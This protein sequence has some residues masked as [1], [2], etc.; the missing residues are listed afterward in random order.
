MRRQGQNVLYGDG[1]V[2]FQSTPLAGVDQDN[3]YTFGATTKDASGDGIAGPPT[4]P[5][6]NV[7]LPVATDGEPATR[8][9]EPLG[10]DKQCK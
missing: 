7:L 1:H 2:E 8:P 10:S 3:I 9:A 5:N 4:G 6:D